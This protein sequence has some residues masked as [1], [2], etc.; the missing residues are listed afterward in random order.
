MVVRDLTGTNIETLRRDLYSLPEEKKPTETPSVDVSVMSESSGDKI[1]LASRFVLASYLFNKPY[2]E[3]TDIRTLDFPL[4]KH[5][6]IK[7]YVE[8]KLVNGEKIKFS[9]LYDVF[10]SEYNDELSALAGLDF[11]DGKKFDQ[12][13]YFFECVKTLKLDKLTR[14]INSL[15]QMFKEETDTEKRRVIAT[16][17]SR[18]LLEKNKL[19]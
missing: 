3:E 7:E 10:D 18:L 4:A 5:V 16:E 15:K 14:N 19:C 9:A 11:E 2:A 13:T 12:A 6:A 8:K 17:M 1:T